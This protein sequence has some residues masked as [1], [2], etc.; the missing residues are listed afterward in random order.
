MP[1]KSTLAG[2]GA[3][4]PRQ[5]DT[6][7]ASYIRRAGLRARLPDYTRV[8]CVAWWSGAEAGIFFPLNQKLQ[9][10]IVRRLIAM[11][12]TARH[13]RSTATIAV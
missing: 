11:P 12:L 8:S 13:P 9:A 1:L 6:L 4:P 7:F 10:V 3:K 5:T 2:P